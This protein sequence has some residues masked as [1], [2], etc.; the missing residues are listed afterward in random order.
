MLDGH[1]QPGSKKNQQQASSKPTRVAELERR[2]E[3]LTS[4]LDSVSR[5]Q[6][7]RRDINLAGSAPESVPGFKDPMQPT[8]PLDVF[9]T[10][11]QRGY[12]YPARH[13]FPIDNAKH[14]TPAPD[15]EKNAGVEP[16]NQPPSQP[17]YSQ[18][19]SSIPSPSVEES[20]PPPG[21]SAPTR[22]GTNRAAN[23]DSQPPYTMFP[24][25]CAPQQRPGIKKAPKASKTAQNT[26]VNHHQDAAATVGAVGTP[27]SLLPPTPA[28]LDTEGM[29]PTSDEAEIMLSEFRNV[30][31]PLFPFVIIPDFV[32]SEQLRCGRPMLWKAVMMAACQLDGA[33]Q[34]VLGNQLLGELATAAFLQPRRKLETL[35]AVLIL[36]GWFHYNINS[37]QLFNLIYLARAMC[38]SLSISEPMPSQGAPRRERVGADLGEHNS[39]TNGAYDNSINAER[40]DARGPDD[41]HGNSS[42]GFDPRRPTSA[43]SPVALEQMRTF[44]GTF[45]LVA[46]ATTTSKRPDGMMNSPYLETCCQVIGRQ[47]EYPTD[48]YLL[49]LVRIQQLSQSISMAHSLRTEGMQMGLSLHQLMQNLR[50][51]LAAFKAQIPKAYSKDVN[52]VGHFHTAE[53]LLYETAIQE[54]TGPPSLNNEALSESDRLELLWACTHAIKN[55]MH[56]RF[57]DHIT[58]Q[59]RSLCLASLDYMFAFL[60]ALKLMT[61]Q[62]PGWDGRRVRWELAF[63]DLIDRQIFDLQMMAERR[64]QKRM[65]LSPE[66]AATP[67]PDWNSEMGGASLPTAS[68]GEVSSGP[69]HGVSNSSSSSNSRHTAGE[70]DSNGAG[71]AK[72]GAPTTLADPLDPF[73]RLVGRL[74]ELKSMISKELDK[75]PDA[76]SRPHN[77]GSAGVNTRAPVPSIPT[78]DA[79]IAARYG[80]APEHTLNHSDADMDMVSP[81]DS[82]S[83]RSK[84]DSHAYVGAATAQQDAQQQTHLSLPSTM[85]ALGLETPFDAIP[86]NAEPILS[87]ADATIDYM[88]NMDGSGMPDLFGTPGW[89]STLH[90]DL[91]TSSFYDSW[92]SQI[93]L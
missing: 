68:T 53:I 79:A 92:G 73:T 20:S 5:Q 44:A 77:F 70:K 13:I 40:N 36:V 80:P 1:R 54:V 11:A 4:R 10:Y 60:T 7:L 56:N 29:W 59:P 8:K 24:N 34:M 18:Q 91:A 25:I 2:L 48:G 28:T 58:D 37:F 47:L 51:Q 71:A 39:S 55:L 61:L 21:S 52:L 6:A 43:S 85:Q 17:T 12:M 88:Q 75:L 16:R 74:T 81:S 76:D 30:L 66:K 63:D 90:A 42:N 22:S 83:S 86:I 64:G 27:A 41:S 87:F 3:H 45:Y 62:T 14:N 15:Q 72:P 49:Q 69:V 31:M 26:V 23:G 38:V 46:L 93:N 35:Q 33:R 9:R 57:Q 84:T 82:H 67:A 89:E 78:M 19:Y 65:C 50:Q 32:T